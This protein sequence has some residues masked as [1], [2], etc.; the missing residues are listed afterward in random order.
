M[1]YTRA[2][3]S[4]LRGALGVFVICV[5][6]SVM[7]LG[8]THFFGESM[9]SEFRN[10]HGRFRDASRKYLSVDQDERTIAEYYPAFIDLYRRG[11]IGD[12]HRLN[13]VEVLGEAATD[14]KLPSLDYEIEP[15]QPFVADPPL[16]SSA[17]DVRVSRMHLA[18]GLMHEGDLRRLLG[19]LEQRAE[20]LFSVRDCAARR[21]VDPAHP[22]SNISTEC[23]LEWYTLELRGA[24]VRL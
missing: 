21:I 1:G 9:A 17:F 13:W 11:I 20:G 3:W 23:V 14:L 12:E 6:L 16:A 2:D 10:H 24:K 19:V 4:V 22:G 15:Q 18:L 8:A 5:L 7:M